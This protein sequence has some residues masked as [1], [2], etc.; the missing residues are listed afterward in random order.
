MI[1]KNLYSKSEKQ[2]NSLNISTINYASF[3]ADKGILSKRR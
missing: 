1:K 2:F 3:E